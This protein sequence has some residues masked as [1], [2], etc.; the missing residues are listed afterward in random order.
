MIAIS[1]GWLKRIE[2][3]TVTE[4]NDEATIKIE[5]AEAQNGTG[6]LKVKAQGLAP[7]E[8]LTIDLSLN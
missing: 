6:K 3:L 8:K 1:R 7:V 2:V 4:K 5:L